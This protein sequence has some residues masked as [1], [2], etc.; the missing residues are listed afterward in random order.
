VARQ[1][2]E[3]VDLGEVYRRLA[4]HWKTLLVAFVLG[5]G[6]AYGLSALLLPRVYESKA[7]IY[8]QQSSPMNSLLRG[9][10]LDIA[11]RADAT[12]YI[13]TLLRSETLVRQTISDLSIL[14]DPEFSGG[15]R[16]TMER[17]VTRL[18]KSVV[19]SENKSGGVDVA[20]RGSDARLAARIANKMLDNLGG[21]VKTSSRRKAE[22]ISSKL[23]ETGRDLGKAEDELLAFQRNHDLASIDE[24]TKALI[25]RMVE[26]ESK[27]VALD[28][29]IKQVTSRLASGGELNELVDLEVRKKSLES[30]RDYIER[31]IGEIRAEVS[32]LP[33]VA[34]SYARLQRTLGV[35]SKTYELLTEQLQLANISQRGEDGDYQVI[36]RARPSSRPVMPRKALN[37]AVG[38]VVGVTVCAIVISGSRPRKKRYVG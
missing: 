28:V 2:P 18:K 15:E 26:L 7:T 33:A 3:E 4:A 11:P 31:G 5:A 35:L 29:E 16:L 23:K 38:G 9:L 20:V 36:D 1:V 24:E 17:A 32:A 19:V 37:G 6:V 21:M 13:V 30:S 27:R 14:S 12:G 22:F 8:V 34:I 10:P 25:S